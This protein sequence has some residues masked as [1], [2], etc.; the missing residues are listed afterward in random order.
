MLPVAEQ[1][2]RPGVQVQAALVKI[3]D[4]VAAEPPVE[5]AGCGGEILP[6]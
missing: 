1:Y 3:A 5:E 2:Q 6:Q 4:L